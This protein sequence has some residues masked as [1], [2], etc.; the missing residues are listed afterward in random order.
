M[1]FS[2][3]GQNI[4]IGDITAAVGNPITQE[5]DVLDALKID[6]V[7]SALTD[8]EYD[9]YMVAPADFTGREWHRFIVEDDENEP[10]IAPTRQVSE[11]ITA[12]QKESKKVLI[13]C[14]AGISRSPALVIGHLMLQ[15]KWSYDKAA[16]HVQFSRPII[17]PNAGF[18]RQLRT[19]LQFF[20]PR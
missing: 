5:S 11:I 14:A 2:P 6:V 20:P 16:T 8:E 7:I 10:I 1:K 3:I 9:R 4:F 13:H 18:V 17:K 19:G 15:N 12:A